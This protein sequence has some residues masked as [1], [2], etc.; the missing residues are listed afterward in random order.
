MYF[1]V[2]R[3][4]IQRPGGVSCNIQSKEET[5]KRERPMTTFQGPA[6]GQNI[7]DNDENDVT[8]ILT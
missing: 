1:P 7:N 4:I 2:T 3:L 8:K 5:G 6:R